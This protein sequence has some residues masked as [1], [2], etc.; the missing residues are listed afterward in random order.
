MT[1]K[2][3]AKELINIHYLEINR[4]LEDYFANKVAKEC[5]LITVDECLK[6]SIETYKM[7]DINSDIE[8]QIYDYWNEVKQEIEKT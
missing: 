1:P 8:V 3:K 4:H 2:E 7:F 5:A 6:S